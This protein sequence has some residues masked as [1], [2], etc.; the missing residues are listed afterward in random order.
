MQNKIKSDGNWIGLHLNPEM[1]PVGAMV[2][3][4]VGGKTQTLPVVTGDSYNAQQPLSIHFG[5]GKAKQVDELRVEKFG[6]ELV[7]LTNPV[8]NQYHKARR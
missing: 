5:L 4:R 8:I 3:V 7:R 1:N 6:R 2:T